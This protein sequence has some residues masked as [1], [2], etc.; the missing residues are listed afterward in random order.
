ME[1]P[2]VD[3]LA[4]AKDLAYIMSAVETDT[5]V[6]AGCLMGWRK[7]K[8]MLGK[9]SFHVLLVAE[10]PILSHTSCHAK[11]I[12]IEAHLQD[13]RGEKI[14][15]WRSRMKLNSEKLF[16][17]RIGSFPEESI[18]PYTNP[19]I[20]PGLLGPT[21]VKSM[22]N[23]RAY[24]KV[25]PIFF[26]CQATGALHSQVANDYRKQEFIL[27]FYHSVAIQDSPQKVLS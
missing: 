14:T 9:G 1:E 12:I 16:Q 20:L 18:N 24:M 7:T 3:T 25:W 5:L 13:Q 23:K 21:I 2:T 8:G 19:I 27:Q 11:L 4:P 26:V 17:Q 15:L 6:E 10:L 22:P